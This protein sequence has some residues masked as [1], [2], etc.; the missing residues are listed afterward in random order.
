MKKKWFYTRL[1]KGKKWEHSRFVPLRMLVKTLPNAT[2]G[3]TSP[4]P[5]PLLPP[6]FDFGQLPFGP[7]GMSMYFF[8]FIISFVGAESRCNAQEV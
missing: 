1:P 5:S 2:L 6:P 3:C 8:D 7:F 4:N